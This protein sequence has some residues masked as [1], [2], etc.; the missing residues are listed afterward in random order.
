MEK[1]LISAAV[2]YFLGCISFATIISS[3]H[4]KNIQE[5]GS[6]NPGAT[7][8]FLF[9][10]KRQGVMVMLFDI[11]KAFIAVS[12]STYLL[13]GMYFGVL[14]GIMAILGHMFPVFMH[15]KGG[16]G[17]ACLGGVG[18]ALKWKLFL[19]ILIA[20]ILLALIANYA[21]IASIFTAAVFP[22]AFSAA[23]GSKLMF[24]LLLPV[25]IIML[26]KHRDNIS[27]IRNRTEPLIRKR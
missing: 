15:F 27:R 20:G 10:G 17:L 18:L 13:G 7:N 6:G 8:V 25:S 21:C 23:Y 22:F 11:F 16:K 4:N 26:L 19:P 12:L 2:G 9:V 5:C 1:I 14:S 3:R 24:M